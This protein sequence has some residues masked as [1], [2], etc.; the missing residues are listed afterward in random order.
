MAA[1][2]QNPWW[3]EVLEGGR[4]SRFAGYF[5]IDW[6]PPRP[7]LRDRVLVPILGDR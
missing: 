4:G 5:D 2:T 3:A 1:S 7:D 6:Q